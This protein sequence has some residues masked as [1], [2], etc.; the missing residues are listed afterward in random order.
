[1]GVSHGPGIVIG[2]SSSFI[3]EGAIGAN[4]RGVPFVLSDSAYISAGGE[5]TTAQLTAPTGKTTADV[6]GGRI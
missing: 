2:G 3:G 1:M 4:D 6:G 5:N